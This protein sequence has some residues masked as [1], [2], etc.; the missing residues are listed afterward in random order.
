MDASFEIPVLYRD[1]E[2]LFTARLLSFG[3]VHKFQV[4]VNGQELFFEQ[5]DGGE[6]RAVVATS[7]LEEAKKI[8]VELLKAIAASIESILK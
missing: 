8:N 7:N 2:L 1:Q 6:Y 5:D 4:D 3:Y